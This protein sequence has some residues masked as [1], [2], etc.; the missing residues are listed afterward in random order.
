MG[1]DPLPP[2]DFD[3]FSRLDIRT[4]VVRSAVPF[5]E[6]RKPALKLEVDFGPPIGSRQ[7]SAQLT[8]HYRA[9]ELV[10]REVLAVVNFAP[11]RIAG[12]KSEVL[13]LGMLNP[14]EDGEVIL[15]GP[16]RTGTRGWRLG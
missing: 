2:V 6:A 15:I 16:D 14:E 10:G 1:P 9:E 4:G 11:R 5:P 12:F 3:T 13:V 7:S 8:L